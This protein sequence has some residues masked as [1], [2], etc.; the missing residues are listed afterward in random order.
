[1]RAAVLRELGK[2]PGLEDFPDPVA[3]EDEVLLTVLAA[4]LKP[5]DRQL[6]AG[7]HFASPREFPVVCGSD[8]VG[9]LADR[10]RVFFGG[11]RRPY[12]AFA[13]RSVVRRQQ[14]FSVPEALDDATA[15][16]IPNPGVSAWLSLSHRAKL[17][18]GETVLILGATGVTGRL[19]VQ[20]AKILGAGRVVAAGRN[21]ASLAALPTLGADLTISLNLPRE[22]LVE[23]FRRQNSEARLDVVI[24]YVWGPATEALL[25]AI[26]TH[27]F[28]ASASETRLLQV[29]E[30]AAPTI[31]LPAAA[32]RS[33][34]LTIMGTA[35][36]PTLEVLSAALRQVFDQAAR[37]ALQMDTEQVPLTDIESA[38]NRGTSSRR[39]VFRP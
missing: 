10:S 31:Q 3:G 21:P 12:G 34:A 16:A 2:S 13:E 6:A 30:S 23:A 39:L 36:I 8:G 24:D 9:R 27:E 19:A 22:S 7:T 5:I 1:M 17:V 20:I 28:A 37:G 15:A 18:A 32:L 4:S 29:G 11:P 38:W 14:C 35:G 26:T 25:A 33:T